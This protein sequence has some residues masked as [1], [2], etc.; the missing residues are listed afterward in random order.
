MNSDR[1]RV[2]EIFPRVPIKEETKPQTGFGTFLEFVGSGTFDPIR[3]AY[4]V[5]DEDDHNITFLFNVRDLGLVKHDSME[6]IEQKVKSP[7]LRT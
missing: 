4:L 5:M 1:Y 2:C 7:H 3:N 6:Y